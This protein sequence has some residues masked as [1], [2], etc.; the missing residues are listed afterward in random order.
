MD[1]AALMPHGLD[2]AEDEQ[3]ASGICGGL[4]RHI[5]TEVREV[6]TETMDPSSGLQL[7]SAVMLLVGSHPT[8]VTYARATVVAARAAGVVVRP[9][10]LADTVHYAE[11]ALLLQQLNQDPS[12]HGE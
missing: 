1:T 5:L 3:P 8:A 6:I 12:C 11:V 2:G 10:L 9:L 7:P 4:A